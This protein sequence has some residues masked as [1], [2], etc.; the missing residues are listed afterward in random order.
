MTTDNGSQLVFG[1]DITPPFTANALYHHSVGPRLYIPRT[2]SAMRPTLL[3]P[4]VPEKGHYPKRSFDTPRFPPPRAHSSYFPNSNLYTATTENNLMVMPTRTTD[5][6]PNGNWMAPIDVSCLSDSQPMPLDHFHSA[7]N[8]STLNNLNIIQPKPTRP[9]NGVS[10]N[11]Q[12]QVAEDVPSPE[13][14]KQVKAKRRL[15]LKNFG[16]GTSKNPFSKGK[17]L[18]STGRN[19]E[20]TNGCQDVPTN[21]NGDESFVFVEVLDTI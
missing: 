15:S 6:T 7:R 5:Q 11:L 9:L 19:R 13:S 10:L 4:S 8:I 18:A 14:L 20:T 12:D 2:S 3:T 1:P 21:S 16:L 17:T